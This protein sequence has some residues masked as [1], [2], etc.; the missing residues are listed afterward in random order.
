M[1]QMDPHKHGV[2]VPMDTAD[3]IPNSPNQKVGT[4]DRRSGPDTEEWS[5]M[6]NS[7]R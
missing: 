2:Q 4:K 5:S 1:I 6:S 7:K 3:Y